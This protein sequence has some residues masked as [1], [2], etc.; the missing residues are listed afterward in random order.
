MG[1]EI[2]KIYIRSIIGI[3]SSS[4]VVGYGLSIGALSDQVA[5]IYLSS[6]IAMV[7]LDKA[8]ENGN[9]KR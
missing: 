7:V 2:A 9:T 8:L 4:I 3:V 1:V 5:T 6:I